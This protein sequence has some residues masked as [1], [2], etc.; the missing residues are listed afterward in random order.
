MTVS[1][2]CDGFV[3][4]VTVS[5]WCDGFVLVRRFRLGV[6]ISDGGCRRR[7]RLATWTGVQAVPNF[8]LAL[9]PF[10]LFGVQF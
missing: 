4:G 3:V 7:E 2:W 5:C 1:Y 10:Q 6:T 9:L 8:L